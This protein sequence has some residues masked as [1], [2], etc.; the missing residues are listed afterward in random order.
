MGYVKVTVKD[1]YKEIVVTAKTDREIYRPGGQSSC[2][3]ERSSQG[4]LKTSRSN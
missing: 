1:A 4:R 3:T 2:E